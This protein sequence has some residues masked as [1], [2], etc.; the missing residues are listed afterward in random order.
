MRKPTAARIRGYLKSYPQALVRSGNLLDY[1]N[2]LTNF[3]FLRKK[4]EHP[5]FGIQA[6]IEDYNLIAEADITN[7]IQ[8]QP[9][10]DKILHLLQ[11]T[12]ELSAHILSQDTT[13]LASQLWGRLLYFE[14]YPAI[15]QLLETAKQR[16]TQPWLRPIFPNL[17][18]P[19]GALIRTLSG[20][21]DAVTAVAITPDGLTVVSASNDRTIKVWN[22][23]TGTEQLTL[24][25]H[26][27][28]VTAVAITP[29]GSQVISASVDQTIKVWN[30]TTGIEHSTLIGHSDTVTAIAITPDG[31]RVISTS[32][33]QTVKVWDLTTGIEQLTLKYIRHE[34][35]AI[36]IDPDGSKVVFAFHNKAIKVYNLATGTEQFNLKIH[37][38][39]VTAVAITSDGS[40]VISA[41]QD[42]TVKVWD[43]ATGDVYLTFKGHSSWVIA[44]AITPDGSRIVS[45]SSACTLKVWDI[46]TGDVYLTF[47]GHSSWITAVAITPDGSRVVSAS[48]DQTLKIWDLTTETEQLTLQSH[49]SWVTAVAITPDG[50]RVVSASGDTTLKLWDLATRKQLLT[51]RGHK[52]WVT[53]IA[54]TPDGSKVISASNDKTL[55]LWDLATGKSQLEF[56]KFSNRI[57]AIAITPDG[58][59]VVSASNDKTLKL[60]DLNTGKQ[61]LTLQGHN[62]WV[63]AVA[64]TPDGSQILSASNDKTLKLWDLATGKQLLTS[65]YCNYELISV[66]IT[67][68]GSQ[69][70]SATSDYSLKVWN[71]NTGIEQWTFKGHTYWVQSVAITPD[72]SEVISASNDQTLKLWDLATGKLVMT[73]IGDSPFCSC[74]ISPDGQTIVA[75]D[76]SGIVHFL[77]IEGL[78][79]DGKANNEI[80]ERSKKTI[81]SDPRPPTLIAVN[82]LPE[83]QH[84][85]T[86]KRQNFVGRQFVF[87]AI[88]TFINRYSRGY[89]TLVG[90]PGM[91]KS[92]ILSQYVFKNPQTIFY[93]CEINHYNQTE[94]FLETLFNQLIQAY[95]LSYSSLPENATADGWFLSVILQ[96][97]SDLLSPNERLVIIIDGCD[98][99]NNS[100]QPPGSNLLYLPRYLPGNIYFILSRRPF[101][102]EQSG[103][104]VETPCQILDLSQY[105]QQNQQDIQAYLNQFNLDKKQQTRK[106]QRRTTVIA[107]EAGIEKAERVLIRLGFNS[108]TNFSR[109]T[110]ISKAAVFRF[111]NRYPIQFYTFK[112]ICESLTL[113]WR[114]IIQSERDEN[115]RMLVEKTILSSN[116]FLSEESVKRI[117]NQSKLNFKFAVE[118]VKVIN[119]SSSKLPPGLIEYYQKHW[120]KMVIKNPSELQLN[121]INCWT[122]Q[123]EWLSAEAIAE[124][125]DEDE[126]EIEL[127]LA[128]WIEFLQW[129]EIESEIC[130][131]WY[132][133]SFCQFLKSD[134]ISS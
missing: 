92:A 93:P 50:S 118:I 129:D 97:I 15:K 8:L 5:E 125:L 68:N 6:L 13:Q 23:I 37:R 35:T 79:I 54:I 16:Q 124:T 110:L 127:I 81:N 40:R 75:G 34:V 38:N 7:N 9:E 59:K 66:A 108:K 74:A 10:Q 131:R 88:Q 2:L 73:F 11:R 99:L 115:S 17:T 32:E 122:E 62:S 117:E 28:W 26:R 49:S 84:F 130:Y 48:N 94:V 22:L 83:V 134:Y 98:R 86:E 65:Q 95:S 30:L 31:S 116:I 44:A 133:P 89:F 101:L 1:Y 57:T 19:G 14:H 60:W 82:Y 20:H 72:G 90:F 87:D 113:N 52:N 25:G 76:G 24:R 39:E 55:K 43:L 21:E 77:R 80:Y 123:N 63:T 109:S 96:Q 41:S 29:D 53:A 106:E 91:G 4:I 111:F 47:K 51:F 121:V 128:D 102:S 100:T 46:A 18:P 58:S 105:P 112:M 27:S 45:A 12:F 70:I 119:Q 114:E 104:L 3:Y 56:N 67:P 33:D 61:L 107:S 103:L 64:V 120:Q 85:I 36:A 78:K 126:Y 132:H 42:R 71:L 69:L